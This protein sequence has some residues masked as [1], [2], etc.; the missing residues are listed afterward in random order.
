VHGSPLKRQGQIGSLKPTQDWVDPKP[1]H[2]NRD[3][4]LFGSQGTRS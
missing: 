4:R 1:D 2:W 3:F